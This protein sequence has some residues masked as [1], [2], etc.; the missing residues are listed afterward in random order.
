MLLQT[1]HSHQ[2]THGSSLLPFEN[3]GYC[4]VTRDILNTCSVLQAYA[5]GAFNQKIAYLQDSASGRGPAATVTPAFAPGGA[6]GGVPASSTNNANA[7]GTPVCCCF[8]Q[9]FCLITC[10]CNKHWSPVKC[11]LARCAHVFWQTAQA[12][13]AHDCQLCSLR[14]GKLVF[15]YIGMLP[16]ARQPF[17]PL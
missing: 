9:P 4:T 6:G 12:R 7:V 17:F 1:K 15:N 2:G 16:A 10:H 14:P 13:F 11:I 3:S 5:K 8:H